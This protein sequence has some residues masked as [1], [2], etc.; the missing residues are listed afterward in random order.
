ME[1]KTNY[2][3]DD[4]DLPPIFSPRLNPIITAKLRI[5]H[6]AIALGIEITNDALNTFAVLLV[7][8]EQDS[9][10]PSKR[11]RCTDGNAA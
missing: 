5:H 1:M 4:S 3:G 9:E 8:L 6:Q 11:K 7:A 10:M 2:K